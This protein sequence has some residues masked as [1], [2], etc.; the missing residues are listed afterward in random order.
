[1]KYHIINS[2]LLLALSFNPASGQ[3]F[4]EGK[5]M[6]DDSGEH[7]LKLSFVSQFW[8]RTGTYNPGT[9]VFGFAKDKG[10]DYGI[11]RFR[12]QLF[13]QL[14]DRI[15][16]FS[17]F[18]ENNFNSISDRK[19][20]FFV[21]DVT[22]EYALDKKRLSIGMGLSGWSGLARFASP[23]VAS[24]MGL[25]A[26]LFQQTTND[27]TDQFLRKL[28]MF[29]KGKLGRLDYRVSVS[30]PLSIQRS[31][32]YNSAVSS[33]ASFSNMPPKS[34]WNAYLQYQFRDIE[35]NLTAYTTGTYHGKKNVFN[36]G[37]G[38]QY[39]DKAVWRL[40]ENKVDTIESALVAAG[41]D[42]FYDAPL[43]SNGQC[44][45]VYVNYSHLDYGKNY[46]RNLGVMNPANGSLNKDVI[47]GGGYAFPAYGTGN[48]IY[49]HVGY[50]TRDN[51]LGS[52]SL[53]PYFSTENAG[54][55]A[56]PGRMAYYST[57]I[58]ILLNGHKSKVTIAY[59]NRPVFYTGKTDVTRLGNGILQYQISF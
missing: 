42:L 45:N 57:G 7:Y 4:K 53:M 17:Q 33:T 56:L 5:L 23:A 34:Q 35:S 36:I 46:I 9:S 21:H 15:F 37:A 20:S 2:F 54:Y 12:V 13:G 44:L 50:K 43:G 49:L 29:A 47:N 59:E 11:R 1:M 40:S 14:T 10:T 18:G 51:F 48:V 3:S 27:V 6:I 25:D 16:F 19:P 41:V 8:A 30:Q 32:F 52:A 39:Q 38:I 24:I 55:K 31:N 58:S 22:G 26:P 28:G